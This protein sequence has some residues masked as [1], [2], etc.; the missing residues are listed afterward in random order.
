VFPSLSIEENMQMG[1]TCGRRSFKE[2][3]DYVPT[4][5][6]MLGERRKSKAGSL[7]GGERQMVAMGRR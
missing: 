6:R 4:C 5:S 7:S 3:F 1:A 2:R